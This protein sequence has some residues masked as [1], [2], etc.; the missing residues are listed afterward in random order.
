VRLQHAHHQ[1]DPAQR[2]GVGPLSGGAR[3]NHDVGDGKD[4][5]HHAD[6]GRHQP[7]AQPVVA[8]TQRLDDRQ[9]AE[10]QQD[11]AEKEAGAPHGAV[12]YSRTLRRRPSP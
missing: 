2:L 7:R 6:H 8:Q 3:A 10:N 5:E 12:V 9:D 1:G 4:H 11:A